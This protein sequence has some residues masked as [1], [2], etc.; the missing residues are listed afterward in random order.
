MSDKSY[1]LDDSLGYLVNHTAR[2]MSHQLNQNF[3]QAGFN[4]TGEQWIVLLQIL[5]DD[6]LNQQEIACKVGKD[7]ASITR[8]VDGL[9]KRNLVVRISDKNDR[10]NK[11][12]Y[13]T[14]EGKQVKAELSKI[15]EKTL[16]DLQQNI[17]HA[18]LENCKNV[19][20]Q[21]FKNCLEACRRGFDPKP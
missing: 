13:L 21:V 19:L 9:E 10:R 12:I 16:T 8:L 3:L 7:K 14:N 1:N 11:L 15:A 5:N 2:A 6:G 20:R 18:D 17:D 4:V